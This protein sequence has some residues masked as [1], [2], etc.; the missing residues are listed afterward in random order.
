MTCLSLLLV[1]GSLG[2]SVCSIKM[3]LIHKG[4]VYCNKLQ[5]KTW[6]R[7]ELVESG[8]VCS[9]DLSF[10]VDGNSR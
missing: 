4:S 9:C 7:E 3:C 10:P 6:G 2:S 5:T 8:W 1:L